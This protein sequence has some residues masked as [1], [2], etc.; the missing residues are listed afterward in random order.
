MAD[1]ELPPD[2][3]AVTDEQG[4]TYWWNVETNET[5]WTK[6]QAVV[7][8]KEVAA[9]A[10]A[11][12]LMHDPLFPWRSES[13]ALSAGYVQS[14]ANTNSAGS[15]GAKAELE[16]LRNQSSVGNLTARWH[17]AVP[18]SCKSFEACTCPPMPSLTMGYTLPP[19]GV[20]LAR[21]A[22]PRTWT[23]LARQKSNRLLHSRAAHQPQVSPRSSAH[24]PSAR[25]KTRAL[26][27]NHCP[28]HSPPLRSP[29]AAV[30]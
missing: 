28:Q 1:D 24:R 22:L 12:Q 21:A 20:G 9:G 30:P 18:N 29:P 15:G 5:T 25:W 16:A 17:C 10:N 2:W 14:T 3:E 7:A 26:R 6:P 11:Q 19:G 4:R 27:G 13:N 8:T 23:R